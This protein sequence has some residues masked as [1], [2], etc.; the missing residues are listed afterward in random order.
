[1]TRADSRVLRWIG[2]VRL[3]REGEV[4]WTSFSLFGGQERWRSEG[5]QLGGIRSCK[6]VG[7]WFDKYIRPWQQPP[8]HMAT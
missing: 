3:T 1:M 2:T 5:I 6:V 7:N 8:G 4:R